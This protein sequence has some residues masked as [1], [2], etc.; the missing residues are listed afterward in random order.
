L[1]AENSFHL[2]HENDEDQ[3]IRLGFSAQSEE[4]IQQGLTLLKPLL[5]KVE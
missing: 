4:K 1:L 3:Y 2:R 5:N